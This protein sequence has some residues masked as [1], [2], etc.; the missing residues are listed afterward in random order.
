MIVGVL[1]AGQLGRMLALAGVPLGMRFRFYDPDPH[2]VASHVGELVVGGWDDRAALRTFASGLDRCSLEF[3]NVPAA[4]HEF[5]SSLVEVRP[6]GQALATSQDRLL[7]KSCFERLG[8]PTTR[9]RPIESREELADAAAEIGVPCVVKS[10]RFG[11]D[12][13]GQCVLRALDDQA[14]DEAWRAVAGRASI[15]EEY[16][17][18]DREVSIVGAR[19]ADGSCVFYPL[20]ENTHSGGILRVSITPAPQALG[21]LQRRAEAALRAV[22]EHLRYVGVLTIEFF[23]RAG[24]LIANEMAPRVHNSGHWTIDGASCSQFENHVRAV[25]G[26][27]LA[28]PEC[29]ASAMV[30]LIGSHA[31]LA[32]LA[33][34]GGARVHL[35]GKQPRE[36]RKLGHVTLVGDDLAGLEPRLRTLRAMA[37][38]PSLRTP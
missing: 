34:V 16:V 22:M 27:T 19:A 5:I 9:H 33:A 36:G 1:G 26:L 32:E 11:Y 38:D 4:T 7:E 14:I 23:V 24:E 25:C 13:K 28:S 17:P 3:E 31:P 6:G 21:P 20:T 8:I 30:N 35:Y 37:N 18:F 15:V 10:R 2:G 12:G 29:R